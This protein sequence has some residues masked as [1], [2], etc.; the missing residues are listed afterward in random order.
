MYDFLDKITTKIITI[1]QTC[2]RT[3]KFFFSKF[4]TEMKTMKLFR[5]I[6]Y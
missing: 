3:C 4:A 2:L 1:A 5:L 6:F